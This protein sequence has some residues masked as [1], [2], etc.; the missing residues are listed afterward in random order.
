M[1]AKSKHRISVSPRLPP[2]TLGNKS[3]SVNPHDYAY[4]QQVNNKNI[5]NLYYL[6]KV[7]YVA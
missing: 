4:T 1:T 2:I 6:D 7:A 3:E 5:K